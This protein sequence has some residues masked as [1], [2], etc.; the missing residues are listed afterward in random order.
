MN[1]PRTFRILVRALR[2]LSQRMRQRRE[3]LAVF[4]FAL[5][6][7]TSSGGEPTP[8]REN[9]DAPQEEECDG[10]TDHLTVTVESACV[11]A[12]DLRIALLIRNRGP[13]DIW[14]VDNPPSMIEYVWI[15]DPAHW[16]VDFALAHQGA[17]LRIWA[18]GA[19]IGPAPGKRT[20]APWEMQYRRIEPGGSVLRTLVLPLSLKNHRWF[21]QEE[22]P[23]KRNKRPFDWKVMDG[24]PFVLSL[25]YLKGDVP[26]AEYSANGWP[27]RK[28]KDE[29]VRLVNPEWARDNFEMRVMIRGHLTSNTDGVP[30]PD[31]NDWTAA[32]VEGGI[33]ND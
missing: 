1:T 14:V 20:I 18:Q 22:D 6:A 23:R 4:L 25:G 9:A 10:R 29:S 19:Q 13:V 33:G 27:L 31:A 32:Y 30:L 24:T 5:V 8:A 15:T 12:G 11:V 26:N 28:P 3:A 17:L 21:D 16:D 2:G 7:L